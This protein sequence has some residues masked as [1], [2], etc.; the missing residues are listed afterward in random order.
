MKSDVKYVLNPLK[1]PYGEFKAKELPADACRIL[2]LTEGPYHSA[3]VD[4]DG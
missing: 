4:S 1:P 3:F 2:L